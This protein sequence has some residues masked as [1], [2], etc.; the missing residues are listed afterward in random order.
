MPPINMLPIKPGYGYPIKPT[1]I[2]IGKDH[3]LFELIEYQAMA[4]VIIATCLKLDENEWQPFTLGDL[5][6]LEPRNSIEELE[7]CMKW[8]VE[9]KWIAQEG[10]KYYVTHQFLSA[11]FQRFPSFPAYR[12]IGDIIKHED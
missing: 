8:F 1:N 10:E 3:L 4:R 9:N 7:K 5:I 12:K 6:G 2:S 11:C